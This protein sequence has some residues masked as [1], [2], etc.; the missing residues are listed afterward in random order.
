MSVSGEWRVWWH[1]FYNARKM[2]LLHRIAIIYCIYYG[3]KITILCQEGHACLHMYTYIKGYSSW[4][5]KT[6]LTHSLYLGRD[7]P[8]QGHGD[9]LRVR[10]LTSHAS[11]P[12]VPSVNQLPRRLLHAFLPHL[13]L[14]S[15]KISHP[16][17]PGPHCK[18]SLLPPS[19]A[20]IA[21]VWVIENWP[22]NRYKPLTQAQKPPCALKHTHANHLFLY[23]PH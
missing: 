17:H 7:Q 4:K 10:P 5:D 22:K 2:W 15:S 3:V 11:L 9:S 13:W 16:F 20:N 12:G 14:C 8:C 6:M 23:L 21:P 18:K 19:H 1:L